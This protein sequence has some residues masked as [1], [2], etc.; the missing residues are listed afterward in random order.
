MDKLRNYVL[1]MGLAS[2]LVLLLVAGFAS[3]T[4]MMRISQANLSVEDR[5]EVLS[6]LDTIGNRIDQ[7]IDRV[8]IFVLTGT[9]EF[10]EPLDGLYRE[11]DNDL[12]DLEPL[13]GNSPAQ[14]QRLQ[15]LRPMVEDRLSI[16]Q[17]HVAIR[18]ENS[19]EQTL[20][21][22]PE[23]DGRLAEI[24][25]LIADMI[26]AE[27]G[28]LVQEQAE[29]QE[30]NVVALGT[31][32]LAGLS[33]LI[34][35]GLTFI[36]LKRQTSERTRVESSL[37]KSEL[38]FSALLESATDGVVVCD[39]I[40]KILV[41]NAVTEQLFGYG[42]EELIGASVEMLVP[43]AERDQHLKDRTAYQSAPISR[44]MAERTE[45]SAQ[46][47][48]GTIFQVEISLSPATI[49][50]Q[51]LVMGLVRDVTEIRAALSSRL[52]LAAMVDASADAIVGMTLDGT[53]ESWNEGAERLYGYSEQEAIGMPLSRLAPPDRAH[54]QTKIRDEIARGK[55]AHL[56]DTVRVKK[57]G[58]R[59]SVSISG[60]PI[61]DRHGS[62]IAWA[63]VVRDLTEQKRMEEQFQEAQ[64]MQ[65]FGQ[66]AGGVAHDF[67]N[68]MTVIAGYSSIAKEALPHG[69]P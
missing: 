27:I 45:L 57:N 52:R 5:F 66:L 36:A 6:Q 17:E 50:D 7:V 19:L 11:I 55:P 58:D 65:A 12:E 10:I 32:G 64:R 24:R 23:A 48:D 39:K 69:S 3:V 61:R 56:P 67:N 21:L 38:Q 63:G 53:I 26:D 4:A 40:G 43:R 34:V 41:V 20:E 54:E 62:V 25:A 68:I 22:I 29:I 51:S 42:R 15:E 13:V 18:R 16:G 60:Y 1:P 47:K 8:R 14:I 46:R 37:Q 49:G 30:T 44:M 31:I 28:L 2:G 35:L 59:V 33:G 9:E